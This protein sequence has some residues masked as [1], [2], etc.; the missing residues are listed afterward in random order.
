[1]SK[2]IN[3][4]WEHTI[5]DDELYAAERNHLMMIE[6]QEWEYEQQNN[7]K[8]PAKIILEKL[9]KDEN[10]YITKSI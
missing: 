4:D 3:E 5:A 7:R 9:E 6:W 1:M 10:T 8:K 2:L